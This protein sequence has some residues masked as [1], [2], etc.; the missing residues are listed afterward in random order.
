MTDPF[1]GWQMAIAGCHWSRT[2]PNGGDAH[3]SSWS[4]PH[5]PSDPRYR[6]GYALIIDHRLIG[7]CKTF[8]EAAAAAMSHDRGR[9]SR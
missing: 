2:L 3:V 7:D 8:T 6:S 4:T 1:E 5:A 9:W